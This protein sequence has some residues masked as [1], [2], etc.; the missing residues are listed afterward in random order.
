MPGSRNPGCTNYDIVARIC[1]NCLQISPI[2]FL[3]RCTDFSLRLT[4]PSLKVLSGKLVPFAAWLVF[5]T[6]YYYG[7]SVAM[8]NIQKLNFIARRRFDL[9]QSTFILLRT[10]ALYVVG[11]DFHHFPYL[12][13]GSLRLSRDH[14]NRKYDHLSDTVTISISVLSTISPTSDYPSGSLAFILIRT[15]SSRQSVVKWKFPQLLP[16][17]TCYCFLEISPLDESVDDRLRILPL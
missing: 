4:R 12:V 3:I 11:W 13:G 16:L 15:F 2:G 10:E 1:T 14:T 6:S 8:S 17:P 9:R 5:P 7:T